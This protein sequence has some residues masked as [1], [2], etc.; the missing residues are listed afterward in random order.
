MEVARGILKFS[1]MP[2]PDIIKE[3]V[4]AA[5]TKYAK[6]DSAP[7]STG[8]KY[9]QIAEATLAAEIASWFND[10]LA[11]LRQACMGAY[12]NSRCPDRLA[13]SEFPHEWLRSKVCLL[14]K[15]NPPTLNPK[16]LRPVV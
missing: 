2:I 11:E 9:P 6:R 3:E 5:F 8:L 4:T 1:L 14:P 7:G 16:D 10:A 15:K 12:G 13:D